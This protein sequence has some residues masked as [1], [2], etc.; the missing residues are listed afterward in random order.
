MNIRLYNKN[1]QE[2]YISF[3][4]QKEKNHEEE[5]FHTYGSLMNRLIEKLNDEE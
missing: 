3:S 4:L 1:T 5:R 2:N